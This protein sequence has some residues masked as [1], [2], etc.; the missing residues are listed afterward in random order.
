MNRDKWKSIQ[1]RRYSFESITHNI[2]MQKFAIFF[3]S[4]GYNWPVQCRVYSNLMQQR[5]TNF[6]K[7]DYKHK[8]KINK[9]SMKNNWKISTDQT[10]HNK[11]MNTFSKYVICKS[12]DGILISWW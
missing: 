12:F 8:S 1:T 2:I 10:N 11:I 6:S 9:N 5:D 7:P 3:F 4:K